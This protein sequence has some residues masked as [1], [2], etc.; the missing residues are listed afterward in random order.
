MDGKITLT[1]SQQAAFDG[2]VDFVKSKDQKVFILTGYA[3]TG[4]TT[5]TKQVIKQLDAMEMRYSL[6]ASTGRAAKILSDK[7]GGLA[8]TVH[9]MIYTYNDFNKNL[10]TEINNEGRHSD[11]QLFLV[12]SF[13]P[14]PPYEGGGIYIVDEA[15]MISD[16]RSENNYQAVFG[17]G[18]LLSD[19]MKYDKAGKFVFIGDNCQL[20]PVG[21]AISPAL[22]YDYFVK[23]F[24]ISPRTATLTEIMRQ[25]GDNDIIRQS[26]EIRS[27]WTA[28]PSEPYTLPNNRN[29]WKFL[30]WR[31]SNNIKIV[32][33][34]EALLTEYFK[35]IKNFDYD[36]ATLLTN[37]NSRCLKLSIRLR[38]SF[39]FY[40]VLNVNDLLLV[41]QNNLISGLMN[42]DLVKVKE[43]GR[44][45]YKAGLKFVY[46]RVENIDD[47]KEYS[48]L[49][50]ED[51]LTGIN[52][53]LNPEQQKALFIDFAIRMNDKGLKQ[54]DELFKTAM[55]TDSY[56]NAL[57]CVYGYALT[58]HKAQGG[59]WDEVFLD[60]MRNITLNPIK[61]NYQWI[62]TAMTRAKKFLYIAN[63]F[64]IR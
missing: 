34:Q 62:Y 9:S 2:I 17:S 51:V 6:C 44:T 1:P 5:I 50:I 45:E 43:I 36:K 12:F 38:R 52:T 46:V 30:P 13:S 25:S 4:K 26:A 33:D 57:R 15:S 20:P 31:N 29:D 63:D 64:F 54:K 55:Q 23:H 61:A 37:S 48:Q 7:T 10:D 35:R 42:G 24:G 58:V 39:G 8:T 22:T 32:A 59:E 14:L 16:Q 60:P 28:A 21:Q 47:H 19:L 18:R 41:T 3:G 40:N 53:N 27:R 56:L 11:G 49:L